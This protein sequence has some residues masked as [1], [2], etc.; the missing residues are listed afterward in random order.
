MSIVIAG[1]FLALPVVI[2]LALIVLFSAEL[3]DK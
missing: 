3:K 1:I 2:G